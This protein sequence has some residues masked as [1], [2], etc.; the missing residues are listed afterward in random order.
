M[1]LIVTHENSDFDALAAAVAAQKLYPSAIVGLGHRVS[2]PVRN[3]LTL[4]K[5]RFPT[6]R[7]S[8]L[9]LERVT[10]LVVVDVRDATRLAHVADVVERVRA[11]A[12]I[13]VSI[14]DHHPASRDDLIGDVEVIEPVGAATTLLVERIRDRGIEIDAFEATLFALGIYT[15][16]GA[17]TLGRTTSRDARAVAWLL[18]QGAS[19]AMVNRYL[20]VSFDDA[21]RRLLAEV[22][23]E[24]RVESV[25]GLSVGIALVEVDA[26]VDGLADITT[27][28]CKL[29]R[30]S[31][32]VT[33]SR[34]RGKKKVEV[35]GRSRSGVID[36]GAAL[37]TLGGGGHPGAGSAVVK[38]GRFEAL[39]E[40]ILQTLRA[41]P[42]ERPVV[43]D[44]MS[45]PVYTV[46]PE[47]PLDALRERLR[48]W[49][50]NGAPVVRDGA[51]VGVVSKRDVERAASRDNTHLPVSSHMTVQL[52]TTTPE[53]PLD[54]ALAQMVREDVGR[55]PVLR[56]GK[57]VGIVSRSDL[58]RVLYPD[59]G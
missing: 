22:L 13:E 44:V 51:L 4:H 38:D 19:L 45:S 35:V 42:K 5:D 20:E 56:A 50:Y 53:A 52:Q 18:D 26:R 32:L 55:L 54:D 15:D 28:A 37:R 29:L 58:L 34:V 1:E 10:R 39:P 59:A 23:A 9:D 3:F 2:T 47:L 21:Q 24:A 6:E 12:P 17:L 31:A 40:V 57:L 7:V 30:L 46:A 8:G 25:G 43:A 49:G 41:S 36:V 11:G 27:E 48:A 16:T 33:L 14:F